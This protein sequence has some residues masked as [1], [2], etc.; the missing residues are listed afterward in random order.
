MS[1][2]PMADGTERHNMRT[3]LFVCAYNATRSIMA[4]ALLNHLGRGRFR[5]LSA[6]ENTSGAVHPLTFECLAAHGIPTPGLHS[7]TWWRY[8]GLGAPPIDLIITVCD[9]S[10]EDMSQQWCHAPLKAHWGT[11]NPAA[12]RG[13]DEEIRCAFKSTFDVLR[14][15]VEAFVQLPLDSLNRTAQWSEVMRVGEI[16]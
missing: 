10:K 12:L 2:R 13:T 9:D 5:A 6:G 11:T 16:H 14:R 8:I 4:E 15:R 1:R 7:K 3:V